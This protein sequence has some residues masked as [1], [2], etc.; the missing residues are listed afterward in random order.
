LQSASSSPRQKKA[1]ALNNLHLFWLFLFIP[2]CSY[3]SYLSSASKVG[4]LYKTHISR[5]VTVKKEIPFYP[6]RIF[7]VRLFTL[8]FSTNASFGIP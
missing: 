7:E 8:K 6:E 4:N 1:Q 2:Y 5:A 3:S